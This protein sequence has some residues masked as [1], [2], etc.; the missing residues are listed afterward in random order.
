MP[1]SRERDDQRLY[2]KPR[3]TAAFIDIGRSAIASGVLAP[4]ERA[5]A[6]SRPSLSAKGR[7]LRG[8]RQPASRASPSSQNQRS[9]AAVLMRVRS[10][11]CEPQGV[12]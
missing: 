2:R 11:H 7:Y 6:G 12:W 9:P 10:Y 4:P 5:L 8:A 3:G 1:A